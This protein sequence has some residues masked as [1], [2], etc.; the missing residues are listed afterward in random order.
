MLDVGSSTGGFSV[1]RCV[2][3]RKKLS[4][5]MLDR[6][7][8]PKIA[9]DERVELHEKTDIRHF[10]TNEKIDVVVMDVSFISV[11]LLLLIYLNYTEGCAFCAYVQ[12]SI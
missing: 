11:R 8:A 3:V 12:T 4:L 7:N 6:S 10:V 5:L 9:G 1:L 2:Q